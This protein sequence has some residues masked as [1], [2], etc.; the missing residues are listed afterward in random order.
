MAESPSEATDVRAPCG[1]FTEVPGTADAV[2]AGSG[3]ASHGDSESCRLC[4]GRTAFVSAMVILGRHEARLFQCPACGY[5]QFA[6]LHWLEEAYRE[7]ITATDLGLLQRCM[8]R[9][10]HLRGL[11]ALAGVA[12][13]PVLD[14]GGGFGVLTRLLRDAGIDCHHWDPHC[15]NLFANGFEAAPSSR[16]WG[17]VIALEVMEHLIDPWSFLQEASET[18]DLLIFSTDLISEPPPADWH[19]YAVEHGQHVGFHSRRSIRLAAKRLGMHATSVR[20]LHVLSRRLGPI[21]R[22]AMGWPLARTIAS[23]LARRPS[24]LPVDYRSAIEALTAEQQATAGIRQ[25]RL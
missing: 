15:R 13:E 22:I 12:S 14:W 24:L 11:L 5:S 18:S 9:A 20:S 2:G 8:R 16:R 6:S 4:N 17:A 10:R 1:T 3:L 21:R 25:P 19:Y 7:P 23:G